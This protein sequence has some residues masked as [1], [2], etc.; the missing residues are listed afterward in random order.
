MSDSQSIHI[1]PDPVHPI[2]RLG[3]LCR[4]IAARVGVPFSVLAEQATQATGIF[5]NSWNK[6]LFRRF[7]GASVSSRD[8]DLVIDSYENVVLRNRFRWKESAQDSAQK[9]PPDF[10]GE[11]VHGAFSPQATAMLTALFLRHT[12]KGLR[13]VTDLEEANKT[14]GALICYGSS[15][16]NF[17]TFELEAESGGFLCQFTFNDRG[18]RAFR[19]GDNLYSIETRDGITYDKAIVLRLAGQKDSGQCRIACAGLSEW[20][21]LAAVHYLVNNWRTLHRRFDGFGE[22]RDFC[23]LLELPFGHYQ[24]LRERASAVWWHRNGA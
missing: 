19:V 16:S 22:R 13:I 17:R 14:D 9:Q 23:V 18:E 2:W 11:L 6:F 1:G 10:A 20:G 4:S 8:V 5:T 12:G 3:S 21:S 15:D 24:Q 7:W